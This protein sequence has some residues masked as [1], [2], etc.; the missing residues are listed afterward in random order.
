MLNNVIVVKL[1][2]LKCRDLKTYVYVLIITVN[3]NIIKLKIYSI[4][5]P[6]SPEMCSKTEVF[7][8]CKK[9]EILGKNWKLDQKSKFSF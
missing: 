6:S 2:I 7:V 1:Y 4:L 8:K 5:T 9:N 3:V